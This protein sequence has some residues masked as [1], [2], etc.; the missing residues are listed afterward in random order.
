MREAS[1]RRDTAPPPLDH[2]RGLPR[3]PE[4]VPRVPTDL[5]RE[6]QDPPDRLGDAIPWRG[7]A[8]GI[9]AVEDEDAR[10]GWAGSFSRFSQCRE[11]SSLI[12]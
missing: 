7:R 4:G 1:T 9:G 8:R 10:Y 11:S 2:E 3:D 12:G 5:H 6:L